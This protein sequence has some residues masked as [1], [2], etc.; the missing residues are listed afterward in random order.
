MN[1]AEALKQVKAAKAARVPHFHA[2]LF[3]REA[4]FDSATE[5]RLLVDGGYPPIKK[6]STQEQT[7]EMAT[8]ATLRRVCTDLLTAG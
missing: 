3:L 8:R 4:G 1:E 7:I 2:Q 5:N 6:L